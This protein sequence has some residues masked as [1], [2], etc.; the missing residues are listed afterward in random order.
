MSGF[1]RNY[2]AVE[3]QPDHE[4]LIGRNRI[5]IDFSKDFSQ[6][7]IF[8]SNDIEQ[9]YS[10]STD[11]LSYDLREAYV[12]LFFTNSDLRIGKQ[13]ISWGRSDGS[14]ILDILSPNDLSEFLT[15]DFTDLRSGVTA[16]SYSRYFGSNY[17]QIVVNP[18]FEP[19]N[20]PKFNTRWFPRPVVSTSLPTEIIDSKP[21][22]SLD[23]LQLAT[24]FAY[25][26]NLNIDLDLSFMYWHYPN[27]S[28]FKELQTSNNN[29]SLKLKEKF[30][31]SLIA[32]YSSSIKL[33][34]R[35]FLKS[36]SAYYS[37]RNF[38]YLSNQLQGI[39][40]ENPSPA[41]QAQIIQEFN[42]N[43]DGFLKERPW[44]I[45][46]I[47]LRYELFDIA[48]STQFF[49]EHIFDY[50]NTILQEKNF[51]YSTLQLQRSFARDTWE[52]SVFGRYNYNGDD[53]WLN[54][55]ITYTGIDS[56]EASLGSQLFGGKQPV[57]NYG[58]LSFD[59]FDGNTFG[60]LK[61]SAYF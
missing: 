21:E 54:P 8:I 40:L 14:S 28:Y 58:H 55:E 52:A 50:N 48:I 7:E 39:D 31:Q 56:F 23:D 38:D 60:Y 2:N 26:S 5:R 61:I 13:I 46:M 51:Y 34:D 30:T 45:S 29:A 6:G 36:E 43:S 32:G 44:L 1:I 9:L 25:R 15:Q 49:N 59:N 35:L 4:I 10:A 3:L 20:T 19:N 12:D 18:V 41:E 33:S 57:Q 47:G 53:F 17:L 11:S 24:R 22:A 27:P 16:I 37:N 42:Q